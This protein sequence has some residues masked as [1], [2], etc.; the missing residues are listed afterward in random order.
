[1]LTHTAFTT[2]TRP[3]YFTGHVVMADGKPMHVHT[4]QLETSPDGQLLYFQVA[5]EGVEKT[6]EP[7]SRHAIDR[8]HG[9]RW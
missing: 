9:D 3:M 8:R 4:D 1:V 6:G 5:G 2:G 7:V